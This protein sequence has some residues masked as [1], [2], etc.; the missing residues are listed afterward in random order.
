MSKAFLE[1]QNAGI[2][3]AAASWITKRGKEDKPENWNNL[4]VRMDDGSVYILK[5][6][7]VTKNKLIWINEGS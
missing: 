4:R 5:R 1:K 3:V 6:E 2:L 7:F